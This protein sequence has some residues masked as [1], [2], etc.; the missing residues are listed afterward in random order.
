MFLAYKTDI[1][2]N[3]EE[4]QDAVK[5][6]FIDENISISVV[7]D[8]MGGAKSGGVA[9]DVAVTNIFNRIMAGFRKD[10]DSNSIRNLMLSAV[11]AANTIVYE[12]SKE[13]IDKNGMGTTCVAALVYNKHCY[14]VSVGDSRVYLLNNDGIS[15]IT[16]DH[17]YVQ[18]LYEQG[19]I[20]KEEQKDHK[21]KNVITRALGVEDD[22]E[23]DYFEFEQSG[24]FT[25]L[26]CSD[27]LSNYCSD[28][29]LYDFVYGKN[30]DEAALNLINYANDQGGSDNI[31]VALVAN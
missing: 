29:E 3:R 19:I 13:D 5:A 12:K 28:Q 30:L 8:G 17:T 24:N 15:Q 11:H 9:S 2:K 27:G 31:T 14:V 22:V 7:C 18:A 26:L 25:L 21:L 20:T 23:V 6:D 4:N 10:A 16:T 1:G